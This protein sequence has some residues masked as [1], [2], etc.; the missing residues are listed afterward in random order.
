MDNAGA[1]KFIAKDVGDA[2]ECFIV[3]RTER[4]V[5]QHPW[6]GLQ[7]DACKSEAQL[8]VL[9]QLKIPAAGCVEE[10]DQPLQAKS[11]QCMRESVVADALDFRRIGENLAQRAARQIGRA[12][13]QIK[14]LFVS[15]MS[16]APSA[17]RPQARQRPEQQ[18]FTRP[19]RSDDEYALSQIGRAA[20]R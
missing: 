3:E 11:A 18:R 12:A 6:R 2:L 20:G 7:Y 16:D 10:G 15:R 14:H 5:D 13:R 1:L 19:R 8:F 17:P 4:V 9:T